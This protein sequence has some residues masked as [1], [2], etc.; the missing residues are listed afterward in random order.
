MIMKGWS[1]EF[2]PLRPRMNAYL[3]KVWDLNFES[4]SQRLG[5]VTHL[6]D[7]EF[8]SALYLVIL[9]AILVFKFDWN[10]FTISFIWKP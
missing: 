10:Y 2:D 4:K 9:E 6:C 3:A 1:G 5:Y 8:Q 7:A